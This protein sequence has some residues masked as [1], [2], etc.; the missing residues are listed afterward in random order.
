MRLT[1]FIP[2]KKDRKGG[3][4]TRIRQMILQQ[5]EA[6]RDPMVDWNLIMSNKEMQDLYHEKFESLLEESG[7]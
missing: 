2:K 7:L 6:D 4:H 3:K 1:V 5:K